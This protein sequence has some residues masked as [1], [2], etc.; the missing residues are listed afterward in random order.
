MEVESLTILGFHCYL[1][2]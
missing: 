2:S 1:K